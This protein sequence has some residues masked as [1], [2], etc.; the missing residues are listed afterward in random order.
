MAVYNTDYIPVNTNKNANIYYN[1][2]DKSLPIK[3]RSE[4]V[5][6]SKDLYIMPCDIIETAV[7]ENYSIIIYG[8]NLQGNKVCLELTGIKMYVDIKLAKTSK[9][10]HKYLQDILG[11]KDIDLRK[12][13]FLKDGY[14]EDLVDYARVYSKT[15]MERKA[16]LKKIASHTSENMLFETASD[17][18]SHYYRK[19]IREYEIKLGEWI[20]FKNNPEIGNSKYGAKCFMHY[21]TDIT[22][23]IN[24][25]QLP[26]E[27]ELKSQNPL[28]LRD[29]SIVQTWDI[30]TYSSRGEVPEVILTEID[31]NGNKIVGTELTDIVF[32]I[33]SSFHFKDDTNS[34]INVCITDCDCEPCD[35]WITIVC[36]NE[37]AI[38]EAFAILM[39]Y[40]Q[41]DYL[42]GFNDSQYDWPFIM[43]KVVQYQIILWFYNKLSLVDGFV[44]KS[45]NEET[46]LTYNY[47]KQQIKLGAGREPAICKYLKVVG[48]M[49]FDIRISFMKSA[50][51]TK[52]TSLKYY[53][54]QN[55][56]GSKVDLPI[57]KMWE[58]YLAIKDN[59][60]P[61]TKLNARTIAYYCIVDAIQCQRL[62]LIRSIITD[63]R[64]V[65][66]LIYI[67]TY[68][69][70]Y[71]AN[72]MKVM[73]LT[74]MY[75]HKEGILIT[76]KVEKFEGK[77]KYAGALVLQPIK[78]LNN[79]RPIAGLD[80]ASLYPSVMMDGNLSLEKMCKDEELVRRLRDKGIK[81]KEHTA[82]YEGKPL[83]T[84]SVCDEI[85]LYPK[86]LIDLKN[87]RKKIKAIQLDM[88]YVLELVELVLSKLESHEVLLNSDE[89][90]KQYEI[91]RQQ[92]K[93]D[94]IKILDYYVK[95]TDINSKL[96]VS[97]LHYDIKCLKLKQEAIKLMMNTFYGVAGNKSSSLFMLELALAVTTNGRKYIMHV[98]EYVQK[99]G[100]TIYYGDTDSLYLECPDI[101]FK[102]VDLLY[103]NDKITRLEYCIKMCEISMTEFDKL[104]KLV[105]IELFNFT[106][107]K[108]LSM[109]YEEILFP[110]MF[111]GKKKYCGLK[112]EGIINFNI[113]DYNTF[114][115]GLDFIKEGQ[116]K[117]CIN[118][119]KKI[120][121]TILD[122]NNKK[123]IYEIV[124]DE[125]NYTL[126]NKEQY[127]IE[128]FIQSAT[129]RKSKQNI[130]VQI[131]I[132]RM[133]E[134]SETEVCDIENKL[135]KVPENGDKFEYVIVKQGS[136]YDYCGNVAKVKK[137][138]IMEF[139]DVVK[140]LKLEIDIDYY[141]YHQ[142]VGMCARFINYKFENCDD[143]EQQNLA[144]KELTLHIK[145]ILEKDIIKEDPKELK[146][147]YKAKLNKLCYCPILKFMFNGK[148][149]N[150]KLFLEDNIVDDNWT[151]ISLFWDRV[152]KMS[153][154]YGNK[155]NNNIEYE[156]SKRDILNSLVIKISPIAEKF[157]D[158]LI[159]ANNEFSDEE[160]NTLVEFKYLMI[161]FA[162][163]YILN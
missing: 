146:K 94:R 145:D 67:S 11:T 52:Y 31:E 151:E 159:N 74:G 134:K 127:A 119:C 32:M 109:A 22:N 93:P 55:K 35:D 149:L 125:I 163:N 89:F 12:G 14:K 41:P 25:S 123:G 117:F 156:E 64:E 13:K 17:D 90:I 37:K 18:P 85:G 99:L 38:I 9:N 135:Y 103:A 140:T 108:Y 152:I 65:A 92:L 10:I 81:V 39:E 116:T 44:K 115:R 129:Y 48:T 70:H 155:T 8:N 153:K 16:Q 56:L 66:N 137:G 68:D 112:H 130:A 36:N 143:A 120:L 60:N 88:M 144:V 34:I 73:N 43:G 110:T 26:N 150:Y 87:K 83:K 2:G 51:K 69:H 162:V 27:L 42:I 3:R 126:K 19:V 111:S 148:Y 79:R 107:T 106:G 139:V 133:R 82:E 154:K 100:F 102:E 78:G 50:E 138:E 59:V 30:E 71:Y 158:N 147:L 160:L 40:M 28:L 113:T 49:S 5:G 96:F 6:N 29:R 142:L 86:I 84:Y 4:Y 122:Y 23:I 20:T 121:N 45:T 132:K 105:E 1:E 46:L 58:Y 97:N 62:C 118:V 128:D 75:A 80:F 141:I 7:Y 76:T 91:E 54:N 136:A 47:K 101:V 104:Q 124:I 131:F 114:I 53:L 77:D 57:K 61:E 24:I 98:A 161:S 15:T 21:K 72:S 157:K 63:Y 33:C 95:L